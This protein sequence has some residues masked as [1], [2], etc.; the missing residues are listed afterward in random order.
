METPSTQNSKKKSSKSG[1]KRK[2][3]DSNEETELVYQESSWHL[4]CAT[5][6]DWR[7]FPERFEQS[8]NPA[9]KR[10]YKV[11]KDNLLPEIMPVFEAKIKEWENKMKWE[12]R[13]RSK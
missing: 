12:N 3:T 5:M 4:I 7:L 9:E 1:K 2:Q 6:D 11:L 8:R 13:K 10:F